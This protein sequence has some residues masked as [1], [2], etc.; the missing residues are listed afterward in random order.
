MPVEKSLEAEENKHERQQ[1]ILVNSLD[2][3]G[4]LL[5]RLSA[6]PLTSYRGVIIF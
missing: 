2:S 3:T 6:L 5:V 1:S 4:R